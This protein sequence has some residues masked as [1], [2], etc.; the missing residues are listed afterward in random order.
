MLYAMIVWIIVVLAVIGNVFIPRVYKQ[1][2]RIEQK[3]QQ[4]TK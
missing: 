3:C 1:L 4:V 2:D